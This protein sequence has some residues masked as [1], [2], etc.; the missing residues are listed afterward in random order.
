MKKHQIIHCILF[1]I[2]IP[3]TLSAQEY[4]SW[5]EPIPDIETWW[6][7]AED[8][9]PVSPEEHPRL[10]FRQQDLPALRQKMQ[11]PEGQALLKYLRL[12]LNGSDGV[13]M[14]IAYNTAKSAYT[15]G[16]RKNAVLDTAGVYTFGHV[17]GYGLL[18]QL[19]GDQRY[20]DWGRQCFELALDGQRDR[21][22]RY[23]LVDPGG[24]LR[25]GPVVGWMAVGY[26]LC[27]NGWDAA[28][29]ERFGRAI[30]NYRTGLYSKWGKTD[31]NLE[32]LVSGSMPPKSNHYG[33]QVGGAALALLAITREPWA[34]Q[35]RLDS[36]LEVSA[37]SMVHNVTQGF[38]DGGYFAEGDGTGSMA[39]Q[40]AY[41]PALQ[42]WKNTMGMDFGA[43]ARPNVRMTALKW[44]YLTVVQD[45]E[46]EIWPVR[47]GYPHNVWSRRGLSG[48]GYFGLSFGVLPDKYS[49]AMKWFYNHFL[50]EYDKEA[51]TP[52][53][54]SVYPHLTVCAFVNWPT[55]LSPQH[56]EEVLPLC[57]RDSQHGFYAWRNRWKDENDIVMT[58]LT[59]DVKGFMGEKADSTFH[60]MAY[61]RKMTWGDVPGPVKQWYT[62]E[63]GETSTLTFE[64]GLS[65]GIDLSGKSGVDVVLIANEAFEGN[66]VKVGDQTIYDKMH[67]PER[68][69]NDHCRRQ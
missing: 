30:E 46:P 67:N 65:V 41:L 55:E 10:L 45:G 50:L 40:I 18:F 52:Y 64:N 39:S 20:A 37:R 38:G 24:A 19:T 56:P 33:M 16:G 17:A 34:D 23:S 49:T 57:Y 54:V 7:P 27:Y 58:A 12:L 22:D 32:Q 60:L 42:A 36:L 69:T 9:V 15:L 28:T 68:H 26:D 48:A 43:S 61:G 47:G 21:D 59:Q 2:L 14:P 25:A 4:G 51:G 8:F 44:L 3:L 62:S 53:A 31:I 35:Q 13:G 29:R 66:Q 11:T 1:F 6:Q 63:N 5:N